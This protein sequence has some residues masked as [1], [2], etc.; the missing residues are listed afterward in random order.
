MAAWCSRNDGDLAAAHILCASGGG[1]QKMEPDCER[2]TAT[3]SGC[4]SLAMAADMAGSAGFDLAVG[5]A[6]IGVKSPRSSDVLPIRPPTMFAIQ[7]NE[8]ALGSVAGGS[9]DLCLAMNASEDVS[10]GKSSRT[11]KDSTT[12]AAATANS[13][14]PAMPFLPSRL[15]PNR[16]E[17]AA[18]RGTTD[19]GAARGPV[20]LAAA[21][22]L[23]RASTG[24]RERLLSATACGAPGL[25]MLRGM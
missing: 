16:G 4:K 6:N 12:S 21:W 7:L 20:V 11:R 19:R 8:V 17:C 5:V 22:P 24:L 1:F 18:P 10:S 23:A 9:L 13:E 2:F 25:P 3:C 15:S 14:S